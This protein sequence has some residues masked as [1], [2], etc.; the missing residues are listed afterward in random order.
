MFGNTRIKVVL[1]HFY[2]DH[3]QKAFVIINKNWK[4]VKNLQD[5]ISKMFQIKVDTYLTIDEY[6]LPPDENIDIING[7]DTIT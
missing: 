2:S 3:R 4:T 1:K 7:T 6:L 5:H